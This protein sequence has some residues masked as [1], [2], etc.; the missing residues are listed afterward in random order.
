MVVYLDLVLLLNFA[1]NYCL[2]R[3]TARLTGAAPGRWRLAAGAA[4]GAAYAGLCV[5]PGL[6][7]LNGNLWRVVF[8]GLMVAAAFGVGRGQL[9]QGAVLLGLS[10]ALGGLA[11]S[12]RLRGFWALL[13]A[14]VLLT[15]LCRWFFRGA[16]RHAG[17]LV[18][19]S[20]RLGDREAKLTALR[21][22]GNT[23]T[24]PFTGSG[25][26]VAQYDAMKTLLPEALSREGLRDPGQAMTLLRRL[27]PELRCRLIP[28]RGLG[29]GGVLL[30]VKCDQVTVDGRR[31]GAF[32]AI[33]PD[34]LSPAGTYQALTGGGQYA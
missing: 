5:L 23:L 9:R 1:V 8:L 11:L 15:A 2:L 26:L 12:L 29:S 28:Y 7:F 3:A 17:Q 32:V 33:A 27:A 24:D 19:A 13:L 22:S 31:A 16:M 25:V 6:G 10:L 30:A 4:V 20:V 21:D 14:A 18:P 34:R